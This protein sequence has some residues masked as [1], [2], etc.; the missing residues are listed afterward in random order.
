MDALPVNGFAILGIIY[1]L[2][3]AIIAVVRLTSIAHNRR[4][5]NA[6]GIPCPSCGYDL[7][8]NLSG[9]CPE[10]GAKVR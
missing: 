1:L 7:T 4:V 9:T 5:R 6:T 2:F 3:G 8:G 10:C